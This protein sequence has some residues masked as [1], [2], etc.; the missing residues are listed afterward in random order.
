M[1]T[2][3]TRTKATGFPVPNN[4]PDPIIEHLMNYYKSNPIDGDIHTE[5]LNQIALEGLSGI[6]FRRLLRILDA[7][8][9]YFDAKDKDCQGYIWTALIKSYLKYPSEVHVGAQYVDPK[10]IVEKQETPCNK[11][12]FIDKHIRLPHE[13]VKRAAKI[14][15]LLCPVQD[16]LV[17]GSCSNY[18]RRIDVTQELVSKAKS[19]QDIHKKFGIDNVFF[20]ASQTLRSKALFPSWA[21]PNVDIKLREYCTLEL[22][23]KSRT[24]GTVFPN[25]KALGRYRIML[26]TKGFITQYQQTSSSPIEHLLIKFQDSRKLESAESKIIKPTNPSSLLNGDIAEDHICFDPGKI[27]IDRSILKMVYDAIAESDGVTQFDLRQVL[28][29]PKFHIRNHLKNLISLKMVCSRT[30]KDTDNPFRVYRT[31]HKTRRK[32]RKLEVEKP[33]GI[34]ASWDETDLKA[35]KILGH[36]RSSFSQTEDSLLILCRI[37]SILLEPKLRLSWC[38][39]KHIIRNLL[40][41]ELVESHDK[42]SDACL[43]RIK[44]L[45]RLPNNIMSINELTAELSEDN[46]VK[47]LLQTSDDNDDDEKMNKRFIKLFKIVRTKI[48]NLLGISSGVEPSRRYTFKDYK[49]LKEKYEL[50]DCQFIEQRCASLFENARTNNISLVTM[51]FTLTSFFSKDDAQTKQGYQNLLD[52]FYSK[53]NDKLVSS[54]LSKLNKR[55]LLTRKCPAEQALLYKPRT[56]MSLKLNQSVLFLLNRYHSSSLLHLAQ[57]LERSYKINLIESN[58]MVS[59]AL[60]TSFLGSMGSLNLAMKI[61]IPKDVV[62][63]GDQGDLIVQPSNIKFYSDEKLKQTN[64]EPFQSFIQNAESQMEANEEVSA[65][66]EKNSASLPD[67][68]VRLWKRIDGSVHRPTLIKLIE[69]LLSRIIVFPGVELDNLQREFNQLMPALHLIELLDL[70]EQL[71]L[72]SSS[73]SVPATKKP[74]LFGYSEINANEKQPIKTTYVTTGEAYLQYCQLLNSSK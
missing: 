10:R 67:K 51:A 27:K 70:M 11:K 24:L 39:H 45:K 57:P 38:V 41:K 64:T 35:K 66:Q 5:I 19:I 12:V 36:K 42:T 22:I 14:D 16:G 60:L 37:T 6:T 2:R 1:R 3:R 20:V 49:E 52:K 15:T 21:D 55:C 13:T 46:E 58:E 30:T 23:G 29:L 65:E 53:H 26:V 68:H 17:M 18:S 69:S 50:L 63:G 43:R 48:P 33:T 31:A 7:I 56:K 74:L 25:D 54:V 71:K 34:M 9:P 40:H 44:Y 61:K 73:K 62:V 72:I 32:K 4:P 28:N 47:R 59:I 8:F